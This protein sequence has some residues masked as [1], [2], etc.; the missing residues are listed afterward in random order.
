[1]LYAESL[2][3]KLGREDRSLAKVGGDRRDSVITG[4]GAIVILLAE[5][6]PVVAAVVMTWA[7]AVPS[8]AAVDGGEAGAPLMC[9][10]IVRRISVPFFLASCRDDTRVGVAS[11]V[12]DF[13][14]GMILSVMGNRSSGCYGCA[15]Y[16]VGE[17]HVMTMTM[18]RLCTVGIQKPS[19]LNITYFNNLVFEL[20]RGYYETYI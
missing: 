6:T 4:A 5:G 11:T 1:M 18:P 8:M 16:V 12:P 9:S 19:I 15:R 20:Y 17:H 2:L 13:F 10:G 7:G 3:D 14:F